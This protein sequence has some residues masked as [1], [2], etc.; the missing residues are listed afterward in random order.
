MHTAEWGGWTDADYTVTQ[1]RG[2][3]YM[4]DQ[5]KIPSGIVSCQCSVQ[6][7]SIGVM[8]DVRYGVSYPIL[9]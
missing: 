3:D 4:V 7:L 5:K 6:M 8:C 9:S 1:V 2:K